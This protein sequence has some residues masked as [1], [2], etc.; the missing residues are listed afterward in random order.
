MMETQGSVNTLN[1]DHRAHQELLG[2]Y[3][4]GAVGQDEARALAAHV[5]GC[6]ACRAEL[7]RLRFAAMVLPLTIDERVPP[8]NSRHRLEARLMREIN[9]PN[10]EARPASPAPFAS[11]D[12]GGRSIPP[13]AP[14]PPVAP[15]QDASPEPRDYPTWPARVEP[16][17]RDR[18]DRQ[19]WPDWP[20]RPDWRAQPGQFGQ[21][22][23]PPTPPTPSVSS[24]PPFPAW[25]V[26]SG[27][28]APPAAPPTPPGLG[29][30]PGLA[31]GPGSSRSRRS[32]L[33]WITAVAVLVLVSAGLLVW[34]L[35]L[36]RDLDDRETAETADTIALQAAQSTAGARATMTYL[37]EADVAGVMVIALYGAPPPPENEVYQLWLVHDSVVIPFG[38]FDPTTA[39][40]AVTL[41][42]PSAYQQ[43][44]IT[45]EPGPFGSPSAVGPTIFVA[46]LGAA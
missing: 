44:V 35:D 43:L 41:P 11:F 25:P 9:G 13:S 26:W 46:P 5:A 4:L 31:Q 6:P 12:S 22:P 7:T 30:G 24:V 34:N 45:R 16:V 3:A 36:R 38:I 42:D 27:A 8:P 33:A 10:V 1:G 17:R 14:A 40:C 29:P 2:A 32:P 37:N 28:A 21:P 23:A 20:E 18:R 39:Q 15:H 19:T